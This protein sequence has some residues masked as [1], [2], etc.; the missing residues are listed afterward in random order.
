MMIKTTIQ[1]DGMMCGM[2]ETHIQDAIRKHFKVKKV[3]ASRSKGEAEILSE[4]YIDERE[5]RR[6]ITDTGYDAGGVQ[7]APFEKK[8][9]FG[10]K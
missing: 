8:K 5:L 6:V 1:I 2:C 3:K 4:D 7:A 10:S 9:L